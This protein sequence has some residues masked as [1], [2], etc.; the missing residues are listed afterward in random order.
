MG[1]PLLSICIATF[2]RAQFLPQTLD[3]ILEQWCDGIELVVVDG[4]SPDETP[5]ILARY[6]ERYPFIV[7]RREPTN[8]GVDADFDKAVG[9][10]SGRYCW[11]MSDDDLLAKGA[12]ARVLRE[13][14]QGSLDL[15]VLNTEVRNRDLSVQLMARRAGL[16]SD[17][18]Y[19]DAD[20]E[21]LFRDTCLHLSFIAATV[22]RRDVWLA[23]QRSPYYGCFFIHIGVI[24]QAPLG[25][26]RFLAAPLVIMR[27]GNA[28]WTPRSFEIWMRRWPALVWSFD[29]FSEAAR[30]SVSPRFPAQDPKMLAWLRGLGAY[31]PTEYDSDLRENLEL[32]PKL[33]A[34]M[35]A[36][37][38]VRLANAINATYCALRRGP[39]CRMK[40]YSLVTAES[41]SGWARWLASRHRVPLL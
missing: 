18:N 28:M 38:P 33:L 39:D 12:I 40:L 21:R 32:P 11:L 10:A 31:G 7:Y 34:R 37:I 36:R 5:D 23:R 29:T 2:R 9:Y 35:L 6:I 41:A 13:L 15:L 4:A 14:A 19:G 27:D 8:S 24:F 25:Q 1:A 30:R 3:S 17:R 16:G 20:S 26:A 22:I